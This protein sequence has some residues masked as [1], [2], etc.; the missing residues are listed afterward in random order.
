MNQTTREITFSEIRQGDKLRVTET[1]PS[2]LESTV[3]GIAS[4]AD[5]V[6]TEH[7]RWLAHSDSQN[8]ADFILAVTNP[9]RGVKQKIELLH[10]ERI[11]PPTEHGTIIRITEFIRYNNV[12]KTNALAILDIDDEWCYFEYPNECGSAYLA[13]SSIVS[14]NPVDITDLPN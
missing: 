9:P 2:G 5:T 11:A 3:V 12:V 1:Y 4:Q 13:P 6:V 10:R 14:W 8:N 7:A